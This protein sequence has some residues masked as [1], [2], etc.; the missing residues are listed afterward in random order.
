MGA[1]SSK[2]TG[3]DRPNNCTVD[4]GSDESQEN[5]KFEL[6]DGRESVG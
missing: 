4:G 5:G 3:G 2:L 6:H 1:A